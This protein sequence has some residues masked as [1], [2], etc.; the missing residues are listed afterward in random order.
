[1]PSGRSV[2]WKTETEVLKILPEAVG[3]GQH[4]K[5]EEIYTRYIYE[6][7]QRNI[8]GDSRKH[9]HGPWEEIRKYRPGKELIRWLD[10]L[11]C[12]LKNLQRVIWTH[13]QVIHLWWV[14]YSELCCSHCDD[15]KEFSSIWLFLCN[16][17]WFVYHLISW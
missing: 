11:P 3:R 1:M 7:W 16:L 15:I 17:Y 6:K 13:W 2:W 4:F 9:Y 12:P 10:L 8:L 5:T 14:I